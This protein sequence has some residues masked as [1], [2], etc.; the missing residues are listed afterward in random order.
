M[1]EKRSDNSDDV[2]HEERSGANQNCINKCNNQDC[3]VVSNVQT[4]ENNIDLPLTNSKET[5]IINEDKLSVTNTKD[6]DE[7]EI[8]SEEPLLPSNNDAEINIAQCQFM[9]N[10]VLEKCDITLSEFK[11]VQM[12]VE[13]MEL[14]K[15]VTDLQYNINNKR[16][17]IVKLRIQ[18]PI[19]IIY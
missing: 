7:D 10:F 13:N 18:V 5:I 2:V 16:T 12:K 6:T 4:I 9:T 8:K 17:D 11:Y 3:A 15:F 19:S 14:L 1:S